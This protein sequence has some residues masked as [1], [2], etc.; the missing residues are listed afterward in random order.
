MNI[1]NK[2]GVS[3]ISLIITIIVLV[4]LA[5][6][7]ITRSSNIPDEAHYTKYMQEMKNV[8]TGVEN[9]KILNSKNG[10]T[11]EKLTKGFK[12][13]KFESLPAEIADKFVS[14]DQDEI[15][16]YL[17]NMEEIGFL[18]ANYGMEYNDVSGDSSFTFGEERYDVY[19]FDAEWTV[20]YVKG[21]KYDGS[22]NYTFE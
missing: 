16:A 15:T 1:K 19:V 10:T 5:A 7:T 3:L 13:V 11:E 14:F 9:V 20:Y 21:L 4:I 2:K 17:V 18:D 22:M 8:Q 6:I 12:K